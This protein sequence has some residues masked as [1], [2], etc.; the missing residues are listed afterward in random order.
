MGDGFTPMVIWSSALT[1]TRAVRHQRMCWWALD[2]LP[3]PSV[4]HI[5]FNHGRRHGF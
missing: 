2:C 4:P 5:R 3:V 1:K